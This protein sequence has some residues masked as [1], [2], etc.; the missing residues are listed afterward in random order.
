MKTLQR[1][2]KQSGL[3]YQIRIPEGRPSVSVLMLHGLSGS[4]LSMWDLDSALPEDAFIVSPRGLFYL[5]P[6]DHSWVNPTIKG[7]PTM[8]DFEPSV[9]ALEVMVQELESEEGFDR[10]NL[11]LMGFSQGAALAFAAAATSN[12]DPIALIA[13]AGLIPEGVLQH[14][15]ELP[16]FWGHGIYD[17]WIPIARARQEVEHLL[18]LGVKVHFCEAEVGHKLGIEC[19]NSLQMWL[20]NQI[21]G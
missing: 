9:R 15:G 11:V 5:A 18:E 21:G 13:I 4:E 6:D 14:L 2:G 1:I 12:L 17:E 8:E 10:K 3:I 7:W 16:V 20:K 19:L